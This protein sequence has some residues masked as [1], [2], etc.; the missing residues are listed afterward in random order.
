[1]HLKQSWLKKKMRRAVPMNRHRKTTI[2]QYQIMT[3]MN[4]ERARLRHPV[5][6]TSP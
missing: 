4:I 1:L 2:S 5:R 3:I 6:L